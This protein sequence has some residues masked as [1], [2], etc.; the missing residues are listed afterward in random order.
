MIVVLEL[1]GRSILI[2]YGF[3]LLEQPGYNKMTTAL[4]SQKRQVME[5]KNDMLTW[6]AKSEDVST[7]SN[8]YHCR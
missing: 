7:C 2:G 5:K 4:Y 1:W 3:I 8:E 6:L